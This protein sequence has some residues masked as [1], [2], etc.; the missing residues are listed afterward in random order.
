MIITDPFGVTQ[1]TGQRERERQR[2]RQREE[3]YIFVDGCKGYAETER[4][5]CGER[6]VEACNFQ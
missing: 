6:K 2:K 1:K 3:T 4:K 5:G